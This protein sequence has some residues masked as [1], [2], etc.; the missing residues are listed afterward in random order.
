MDSKTN[1]IL[2]KFA[3]QKVNLSSD[4]KSIIQELQ[5]FNQILET[6]EKKA[7][8]AF[9]RWEAIYSDWYD[10]L[11]DTEGDI[12]DQENKLERF[13]DKLKDIGVDAKSVKEIS[14]AEKLIKDLKNYIKLEKT[15]N[16]KV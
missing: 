14:V 5:L 11:N 2:Q 3:S 1:E 16:F 8:D 9:E 6:E 13:L 10:T 12:E 4:I 7:Y 15:A